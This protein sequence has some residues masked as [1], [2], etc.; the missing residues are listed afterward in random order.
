MASE[1]KAAA[2]KYMHKRGLL[3][4]ART[5]ALRKRGYQEVEQRRVWPVV[6]HRTKAAAARGKGKAKIA[7]SRYLRL[8]TTLNVGRIAASKVAQAFV[9]EEVNALVTAWPRGVNRLGRRRDLPVSA[10][11]HIDAYLTRDVPKRLRER[12]F[13]VTSVGD[14]LVKAA[15]M[16]KKV[17]EA[18]E[19]RGGEST[20]QRDA[21]M[22]R[23]GKPRPALRNRGFGPY[24]WGHDIS[25]LVFE[26]ICIKWTGDKS[27][28]VEV[29][30]GS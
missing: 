10:K 24:I 6:R 11:I 14:M 8:W 21:R 30:I 19:K 18:D 27:C 2:V 5:V 4:N 12:V 1:K 17:Y 20:T 25:D 29:G 26:Y 13:K 7:K 28:N 15:L 9:K 22:K 3:R 23:A 16:Y